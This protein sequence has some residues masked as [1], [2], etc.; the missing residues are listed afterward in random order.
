MVF[1]GRLRDT[2][3]MPV[4]GGV[5]VIW[6]AGVGVAP[7]LFV[8]GDLL[9]A[10]KSARL[11]MSRKV[12][13]AQSPLHIA[14]SRRRGGQLLGCDVALRE[15]PIETALALDQLIPER[16]GRRAHPISDRCD[17]GGLAFA[18]PQFPC[19]G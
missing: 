9:R 8:L 5:V 7:Q 2:E 11:Q 17:L 16:P 14:D 18:E 13:R 15:E 19:E 3:S 4:H 1:G 12:N 6:T 10:Q